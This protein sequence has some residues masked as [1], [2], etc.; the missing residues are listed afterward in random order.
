M[1]HSIEAWLV[2]ANVEMIV[3]IHALVL[4]EFW[5][6]LWH[7]QKWCLFLCTWYDLNWCLLIG[8]IWSELIINTSSYRRWKNILIF[9]WNFIRYA[10]FKIHAFIWFLIYTVIHQTFELFLIKEVLYSKADLNFELLVSQR[11]DGGI[12]LGRQWF[13]GIDHTFK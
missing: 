8:S 6:N 13:L 4:I 7:V 3:N 11:N 1:G 12:Y 5:F 2:N 9:P 10:R